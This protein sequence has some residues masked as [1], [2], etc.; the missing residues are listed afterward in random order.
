MTL[1]DRYLAAVAA[2]LPK[3]QREDITAE[4]RDDIETR[5]EGREE[6]LGRP[7]TDDEIETVLREV[8]HPLTVAGRY[9]SG[10]Q[11]LVG[12][13]L[14]PWWLF[15]VKVGLVILAAVILLGAV[16]QTVVGEVNFGQAIGQGFHDMFNGGL[17]LIALATIAAFIIERQDKKPAFLTDWRVKDLK[18]FEFDP[19]DADT[20]NKGIAD[21]DKGGAR[22]APVVVGFN[23]GSPVARALTSAAAH[24]VLLLWWA[25]AL[26]VG[27]LDFSSDA[28]MF[29]GV[30]YGALL[31][32]MV[33]L[34]WWP[35]I[36]YLIARIAFDLF[37][38]ANPDAVRAIGLGD[39]VLA[40]ARL[41]GFL[42]TWT[43]SP[44]SPIV[45]VPSVADLVERLQ[46]LFHGEWTLGAILTL[47]VAFGILGAVFDMLRALFRMARGRA[48]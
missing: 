16:V 45:Q 48:D 28:V 8:G 31:N 30:G 44:L 17:M 5:I 21:S 2:Q 25:G 4:L 12:P 20:I 43:S 41:A 33:A 15:G 24:L 27:G 35:V 11:H 6:T 26:N 7:L 23:S 29:D 34:L 42:W 37:R 47:I 14:Y 36:G 46:S 38:A 10:P 18:M 9:R 40:S 32:Q 13:E 1:I 3:A 39:F 22:K 19:L